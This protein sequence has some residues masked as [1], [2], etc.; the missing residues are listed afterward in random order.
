MGDTARVVCNVLT[1]TNMCAGQP[2]LKEARLAMQYVNDPLLV[3]GRK[4]EVR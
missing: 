3:D 1:V 4:V 2:K